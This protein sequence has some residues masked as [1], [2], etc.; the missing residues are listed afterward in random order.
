M[1]A[2]TCATETPGLVAAALYL[3]PAR[4]GRVIAALVELGVFV[5]EFPGQDGRAPAQLSADADVLV[6]FADDD[7]AH[8]ALLRDAVEAGPVVIAV[9]PEGV[10]SAAFG[11]AGA[12]AVVTDGTGFCPGVPD[13]GG[14]G[15]GRAG[16]PRRGLSAPVEHEHDSLRGPRVP[17]R[18]ALAGSKRFAC[19]AL[20]DGAWSP[21]CTG[22]RQGGR[23][24]EGDAAKA[25]D[26]LGRRPKRRLPED[27]RASPSTESRGVGWRPGA[28]VRRPRCG[29]RAA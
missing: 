17:A 25:P 10:D 26:E 5:R 13:A 6:V 2:D 22:H 28:V 1:T 20:A 7:P 15:P 14:R 18:R 8:R 3:R 27:R 19:R 12:F 9:L 29:L 24:P 21:P 11:L 4:R 16:A 23:G